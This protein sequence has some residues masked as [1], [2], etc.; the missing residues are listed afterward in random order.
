MHIPILIEHPQMLGTVLRGTPGWVW[1]LLAALVWLGATQLRDRQASLTRVTILPV[2]M[3]GLSI[4]GIAGAFGA[5]PMFGYL[6]LAWMLVASIAFAAIGITS[7]PAGTQYDRASGT[8]F[9]PGSWV[10]MAMIA[11]IFVTR[12]IVNVDVAI[13]PGVV[14]DGEYTLVIAALYG[15]FTGTFLGRAARLWR[16][17]AEGRMSGFALQR[18]AW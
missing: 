3:T 14:R 18:D 10:P 2:V 8:F 6:M 12:Y 17:A 13:Q 9:L 15:L 16:M 5:S 1:G 4:W 7:A 11:G